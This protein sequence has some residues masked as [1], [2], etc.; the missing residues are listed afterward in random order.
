MY[1]LSMVHLFKPALYKNVLTV[2]I[3]ANELPFERVRVL[4]GQNYGNLKEKEVIS[5]V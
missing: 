5:S 2:P 4:R 3:V 1:H